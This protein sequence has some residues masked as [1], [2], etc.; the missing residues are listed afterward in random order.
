VAKLLLDRRAD[1]NAHYAGDDPDSGIFPAL[2]AAIAVSRSLP[3]ARL[4]LEAGAN[5][6]DGQSMYHAA[7]AWTNDAV[8]LLVQHG[9]SKKELSYCLLHKI[10]FVHEAGIRRFLEHGADPNVRHP[11]AGETAL[12]WAIKRTCPPS[13]IQM[14]LARGADP[15]ARTQEG[16]T[17]HPAIAA[18]TPLDLSER[19]G[20]V[21]ISAVLRRHGAERV[22]T[23]TMDDFLI[24]CARGDE[25]AARKLLADEPD[26]MSR[27]SEP[28][29]SLIANVAQQNSAAG[30]LLMLDLGFDPDV[31]G[32]G[33]VPA[34][35]WAACRGNPALVKG[36]LARGVRPLDLGGDAGTPVHQALYQRWNDEGDYP[37]VLEALVAGGV[38]LPANLKPSGDAAL[39]EL[40]ARLRGPVVPA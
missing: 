33:G 16:Q 6:D 28:D 38:P 29:R 26:L 18:W 36:M 24:A 11:R 37:G 31:G 2:Y 7:E 35:H 4:L 34:L 10:D 3:L 12:H 23:S 17:A 25:A 30:V 27:L 20:R 13:V 39:D 1:P 19:L 5:P 22:A 21:E 15:N 32:W 14:L 9:V 40:V 8:D